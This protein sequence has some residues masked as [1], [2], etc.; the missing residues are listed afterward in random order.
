MA[1][2][3]FAGPAG[4]DTARRCDRPRLDEVPHGF[5]GRL[6]N[7]QPQQH[8]Q[9]LRIHGVGLKPGDQLL[10]LGGLSE[11]E[12]RGGPFLAGGNLLAVPVHDLIDILPDEGLK[13]RVAVDGFLNRRRLVAG[14][15]AGN[16]PA[17]LPALMVVKGALGSLAHDEE[18]ATFQARNSGGL[19]E[20]RLRVRFGVHRRSI[21]LV[22]YS[23]TESSPNAIRRRF[24]SCTL[25]EAYRFA[26]LGQRPPQRIRGACSPGAFDFSR[27]AMAGFVVANG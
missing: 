14:D 1:P 4:V 26:A 18:L 23:V 15:V 17:P 6:E 9:S 24:L 7:G 21:W 12:L 22:L 27:S 13:L 25:R 2:I 19:L 11:E 8:F 16:I 10:G 5:V 3:P 20:E